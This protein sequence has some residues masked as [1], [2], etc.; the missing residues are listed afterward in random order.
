MG[1]NGLRAL[2]ILSVAIVHFST[3]FL[4]Y[5]I[6]FDRSFIDE[7]SFLRQIHLKGMKGVFLFFGISGFLITNALY[8]LP[9]SLNSSFTFIKRRILRIYPPFIGSLVCLLFVQFFFKGLP[10]N[11]LLLSISASTVFMHDLIFGEYSIINPVTWS[12]EIEVQFYIFAACFFPLLITGRKFKFA[13]A[14]LLL[15]AFIFTIFSFKDIF[16]SRFFTDYI[17]FFFAGSLASILY[18]YIPNLF[19]ESCNYIFDI[20][21]LFLLVIFFANNIA[22]IQSTALFFLL[23]C[24]FKLKLIASLFRTN[25]FIYMAKVSYS[26]YLLHYAMFHM[27]MLLFANKLNSLAGYEAVVTVYMLVFIPISLILSYPFYVLF[28]GNHEKKVSFTYHIKTIYEQFYLFL[29]QR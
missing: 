18:R 2:A 15:F 26:Y 20:I 10:L 28:E 17:Y 1:I 27:L 9:V 3:A 8:K 22:L 29:Y 11:D 4:D 21:F 14:M 23:I 19:K 13:I 25:T 7:T 16:G 6:L 5:N 24:S 12:L